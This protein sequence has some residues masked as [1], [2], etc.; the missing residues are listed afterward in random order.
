MLRNNWQRHKSFIIFLI[1]GTLTSG[2][3]FG[4][5][6][7]FWNLLQI[8]YTV[9]VSIAYILGLIFHFNANRRFTFNSHGDFFM[10]HITR[11]LMMTALNYLV[12]I[13]IVH[14]IVV[15]G[16]SPYCG[17]IVAIAVNIILTYLISR[18]W[19]FNIAKA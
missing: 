13:A 14:L 1:V 6:Y 19:V 7:I 2:L 5:F 16:F 18:F 15:S 8:N 4:S 10:Q 12:T 9:A 11:Y 3:Y 17:M